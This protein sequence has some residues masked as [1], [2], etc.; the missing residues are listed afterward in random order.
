MVSKLRVL[1]FHHIPNNGSFIFSLALVD[2]LKSRFPGSDTKIIDYKTARLAIYDYLKRFKLF[3]KDPLF[4][5]KRYQLWNMLLKNRFDLDRSYPR[6]SNGIQMLRYYASN[7]DAML[8][9]MDVWCIIKGTSR[10]LF[11]NIYWL[12]EKMEIPKLAYAVSAYHS[13]R[14]LIAAHSKEITAYLNEFEVIGSRDHYTHELVQKHRTKTSGLLD[15]VPDPA[16]LYEIPRTGIEELAQKLG[17][18]LNRP[19]LG[20]LLF[21]NDLI[22]GEICSHFRA[23]GYQIVAL[24]MYNPFAD[25]NLGYALDPIQWAEFFRLLTFCV[26]D[27]FHGTVF[28]I[29][30]EI[31]FISLDNEKITRDQSKI[32]DLLTDFELTPCYCHLYE[33]ENSSSQILFRIAEIERNWEEILKRSIGP[34]LARMRIENDVFSEKMRNIIAG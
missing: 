26:T 9:G 10:P 8:V 34:T 1:T 5:Y 31:P 23:R 30:N 24:S 18:D 28:C 22:S 32:Y 25:L 21:N 7:S 27:R 11:P 4:Y 29:K 3:P 15:R 20:L 2:Q 19:L 12:P 33:E 17:V 16:L 14:A 6:F 13:D